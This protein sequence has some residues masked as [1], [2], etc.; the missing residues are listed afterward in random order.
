MLGIDT[1]GKTAS[2]ALYEDGIMLGQTSIYTSKTHSQVILPMVK[3]I[4]SDCGRELSQLTDIAVSSGPGSYTGIRIGIAAVKA[5]SF[6]LDISCYAVSSLEGLAYNCGFRGYICSVMKARK[7]LVYAALFKTENDKLVRCTD[8]KI[9]SMSE[10]D[11][12]LS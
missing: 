5:M 7:D 1:S 6:A 11:G 4:M 12:I 8:E 10:L 3:K 2:A 9:I